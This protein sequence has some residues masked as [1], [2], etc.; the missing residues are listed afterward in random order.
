VTLPA[1]VK[2]TAMLAVTFAAGALAGVGYERRRPPT[3]QEGMDAHHVLRRLRD[4]LGLDSAQ[5][6]A[7]ATI[8][9]RR[10]RMVD[11]TWHAMQPHVHATMDSTLQEVLGVLRP[12]QAAKY[13]KMVEA[14]HPRTPR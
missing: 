13:E 7:I 9:A 10:Q 11:S 14:M 2:G 12:D 6:N 8:L 4:Q 3:H 1:W 5:E